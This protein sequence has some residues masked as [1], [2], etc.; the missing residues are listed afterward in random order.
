MK[1]DKTREIDNFLATDYREY[2]LS[3][4]ID[5]AIPSAC[6]GLKPSQRKV[7]K[8]A[9][10]IWKSKESKPLK[11]FQFT[12]QIAARTMYHHGDAS[13]NGVVI[14]M[15]QEFRHG[16]PLLKGI[17]QFGDRLCPV[18][19]SP[20]YV[21]TCLNEEARLLFGFPQIAP[22]S[23]ED[24]IT[25]EPC[26]YITDIPLL[27]CN[28]SSGIAV[29]Y[30]CKILP[31]NISEIIK[32][33]QELIKYKK[34]KKA[35]LK[36]YIKSWP[37]TWEQGKSPLQWKN[38]GIAEK[39]K[40]GVRISLMGYNHTYDSFETLLRELSNK[41]LISKYESKVPGIYEIETKADLEKAISMLQLQTTV[42]ENIT[43]IGEENTLLEYP[44]V[45]EYLKD[46]LKW[47]L[48]WMSKQKK[49][50]EEELS[51]QS[52]LLSNKAKFVELVC[53]GKIKLKGQ[54][55]AELVS[56]IE[57]KKLDKV[58]QSYSYLL[59]MPASSFTE[60]MKSK[61]EKEASSK[62][63]EYKELEKK[64]PETLLSE[65][66]SFLGKYFKST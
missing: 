64:T 54:K 45:E 2:A 27:L 49:R 4:V 39:T 25:V 9:L 33:L 40:K 66:L 18:A 56:E 37:G 38:S 28:G 29:G 52:S 13:L 47:R 21:S 57:K 3:V 24:G 60:E 59:D 36:P 17:G 10:D 16:I 12:G 53:S 19:A 61:L 43:C 30:A 22:L 32:A 34:I 1:N 11:V 15:S 42:T 8:T 55:R 26:F 58:N 41:E 50:M 48:K 23:E 14:Q 6:D 7:L 5:R 62:E 46:W 31:R 35:D 65:R 51:A 44:N 20:R 63:K